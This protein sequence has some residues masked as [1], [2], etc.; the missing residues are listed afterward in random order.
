[1]AW[2][3]P[4]EWASTLVHIPTCEDISQCLP[5]SGLRN[6]MNNTCKSQ[7]HYT[8][9]CLQLLQAC[10]LNMLTREMAWEKFTKGPHCILLPPANT[11][12]HALVDGL[13]W[14][15]KWTVVFRLFCYRYPHPSL[16]C[17]AL[18]HMHSKQLDVCHVT[19]MLRD[20]E[21][22]NPQ[23]TILGPAVRLFL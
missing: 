19:A 2:S 11:G 15:S 4:Q 5:P 17:L 10:K 3:T 23:K 21:K 16:V 22:L 9:C 20:R 7:S 8:C 12:T 13:D 6:Y 1:M 18:P 14:N